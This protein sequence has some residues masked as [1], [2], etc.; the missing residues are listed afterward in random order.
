VPTETVPLNLIEV[1]LA[2]GSSQQPHHVGRAR[3]QRSDV[4][5]LPHLEQMLATT[6]SSTTRHWA[7]LGVI[8]LA[9]QQALAQTAP[10]AQPTTRITITGSHAQQPVSLAG[11][12]DVPLEQ[13]PISA[14]VITRNR[15]GD[16]GVVDLGDITRLDASI[17]DAYN[18]TGYINQIAVRGFTL[19]NRSNFR[20]DGLPINAETAILLANK[21]ALEVIKG[22]SGL[23]AGISA[24]GGLVN[25]VIKRPTRSFRD[26][27]LHLTQPGTIEA[28]VDLGDR[29]G[30]DAR[31]GWRLNASGARL[32]PSTEG[33]RGS[34][35]LWALAVDARLGDT[36]VEA[37]AEVSRQSQPSTPGFSLLANRLPD[38]R[39]VNPK[40][41]L[42]Q[43]AWTLPVVFGAQ[44]GSLRVTQSINDS[45]TVVAA[46]MRQNLTTDDR[47]A[48]PFGCSAEDVYDRYCSDGSFDFYDFRSEGERRQSDAAQLV[49]HTR[50]NWAGMQ[51]RLSVGVLASRHT[52]RFGQQAFNYVGTGSVAAPFTTPADP[53]LTDENTN[54]TERSTEWHLQNAVNLRP[55][56]T[57]WAGVRHSRLN[58]QSIRT[59]GSR[60]T[61]YTQGF[62]TPWL[63]ASWQLQGQAQNET[64]ATRA[65]QRGT[66]TSAYLSWG[67][68]VET[69]VTP[70][71]SRYVNA[72]ATLPALKSRQIEL[73]LKHRSGPWEGR[74]AVFDIERPQWNDLLAS[75]GAVAQEGC[76]N[77]EPC[78]RAIDGLSQHTGL[79]AEIEWRGSQLSLRGSALWLN[80]TR[81]GSIS[82]ALNGL[83][84]TNVP[85]RS[86]RAQAAWTPATWTDLSLL[87]FL[88]HEGPRMVLPDNSVATPGWTRLDLGAL[89][90]IQ[91]ASHPITLR[92]NLNNATDRRA[93]QE[94]P[95]QF[96]HAYLYPLAP[97]TLS[98]SLETRL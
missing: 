94:S 72:G 56:V 51:H 70:N 9:A 77:A 26:V 90:R 71:R 46:L 93:W 18:A 76:S 61:P 69:E 22:T 65:S 87:A 28:T 15:L 10:V 97:R 52:A 2:Q 7:T 42:N 83:Q 34:R 74:F 95:Y 20:R 21:Q 68:G 67:E 64:T 55:D 33:S 80:A 6:F 36:L 17:T 54:R 4:A 48:F 12:G 53:S 78:R 35:H 66:H 88:V 57:L 63:A 82:A 5:S 8:A 60:E 84:P 86:L 45:T 14:T 79:E 59:D 19:D 11:F 1:I 91:S 40:T 24:P 29:F 89:Y 47:V 58:R 13:L 96:G 38:A 16:A 3:C 98:L 23:Q 37:E 32:N 81:K 41:N 27:G 75:T 39:S 73:G 30:P 43:Q 44:T 49:V 92:L 62:T 25:L 31:F 85:E 50:K